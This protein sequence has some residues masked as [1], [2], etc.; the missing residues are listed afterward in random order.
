MHPVLEKH[1]AASAIMSLVETPE[2]NALLNNEKVGIAWA[3]Q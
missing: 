1:S 3:L 2:S